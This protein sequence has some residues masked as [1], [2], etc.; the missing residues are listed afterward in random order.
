MFK[1]TPEKE[2]VVLAVPEGCTDKIIICNI[3]VCLQ[4]HQSVI[5]S[6]LTISDKFFTQTLYIISDPHQTVSYLPTSMQW[7]TTHKTTP[8]QNKPKLCIF[9]KTKHRFKSHTHI[10]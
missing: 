4:G 1:I 9:I 6:Y 3:P 5:K 10:I 8:N 7:E 2:T